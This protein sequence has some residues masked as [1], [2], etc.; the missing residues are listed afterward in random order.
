MSITKLT[1]RAALALVG[2]AFA[3]N[4]ALPEGASRIVIGHDIVQGLVAEVEGFPPE[5]SSRKTIAERRP[6]SE[7]LNES[8]Y[9]QST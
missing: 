8:P 2:T 4:V 7:T 1:R 3:A 6:S 9:S 5:L